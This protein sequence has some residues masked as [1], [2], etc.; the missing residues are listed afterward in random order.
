[1]IPE[2]EIRLADWDRD[3]EMI[4]RIRREV[5][6]GEQSVPPDVEWDGR[7]EECLH[8]VAK[9]SNRD[10]IGTGRLHAS[11]K[12]GRMA[13]L[14]PWRGNGVGSALLTRL[15]EE[16]CRRRID[17]VF[18]HAQSHALGFYQRAGFEAEGEEFMEAGIPHRLMRRQ[19]RLD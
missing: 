6:I 16:A 5:F 13:V 4:R 15:V 12:I 19:T 17:E 1:M 14:R 11:G 9:S 10:A 7:D 8:V 2:F 18:L 3:R